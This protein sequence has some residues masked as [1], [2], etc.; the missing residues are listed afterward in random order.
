M[1]ATADHNDITQSS[2]AATGPSLTCRQILTPPVCQITTPPYRNQPD[3]SSYYENSS[4][5][6]QPRNFPQQ[7]Q[8]SSSSGGQQLQFTPRQPAWEC[9]FS[10]DGLLLAVAYGAPDPVIRIFQYHP[11]TTTSTTNNKTTEI[12]DPVGRWSLQATLTGIHEK[13]V[14]SV[15]F[16]PLKTTRILASA[17]FDGTVAI[18]EPEEQFHNAGSLDTLQIVQS[19]QQQQQQTQQE[20]ISSAQ[21]EGHDTEVKC[22]RWNATGSLLATCGRDKSVW[23]WEAFLPGSIGSTNNIGSDE[24]FECLA[25]LHGHEGDVK[26][27]R[28]APS[29]GAW[30]N[31]GDEILL[32]AS[33]DDTIKCW[34][35]DAG[36][37]YCVATLSG[38]HS[39]TIWSLTLSP[40]GARLVAGSEDG[41]IS[42][43][44]GYYTPDER[45]QLA[46]R[47]G[48]NNN[49]DN[50]R[51]IA[52]TLLSVTT[53]DSVLILP[54]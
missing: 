52:I 3:G 11:T 14:R 31:D 30:G 20:W 16:A 40:S 33:Y 24:Q 23:I 41:A 51:D 29:H 4:S 15:A 12:D 54:S 10:P 2:A 17:S 19:S 53:T 50:K 45:E 26:C 37:W 47:R 38:V 13:T 35:E 48:T 21:L 25:V 44:K 46:R 1:V 8:S 32:S 27:V 6:S 42:I 39:S 36:D 28:F 49:N 5:P 22:V 9:T 18:W 43:Y 34:A 7:Q